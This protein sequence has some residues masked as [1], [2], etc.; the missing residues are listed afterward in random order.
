MISEIYDII[1]KNLPH[2]VSDTLQSELKA[3]QQFRELVPKLNQTIEDQ[4]HR[5]EKLNQT[6]QEQRSQLEQHTQLNE[7]AALIEERERNQTISELKTK[8]LC[9]KE[10]T[11]L[12][13]KLALSLTRNVEYRQ[14]VFGSSS[15]PSNHPSAY[16]GQ[17][18]AT[19]YNHEKTETT[20]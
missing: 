6:I 8:L 18:I 10:K 3:L 17:T 11:E 14:S 9:E 2:H 12:A 13:T 15:T 20:S 16:P 5:I 4:L 1:Q 19:P 7:R